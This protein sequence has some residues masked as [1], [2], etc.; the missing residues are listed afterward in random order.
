MA[1]SE[2]HS[3]DLPTAVTLRPATG[4]DMPV[5]LAMMRQ[6]YEREQTPFDVARAERA[7]RGLLAEPVRGGIILAEQNGG[8]IGYMV[9]TF[10]YSLEMAG[11]I[12]LV[13]ELFVTAEQRGRGVGS[14]LLAEAERIA[15]EK[16]VT[17]LILEVNRDNPDATRLY[18]R[19]GYTGRLKY[20]LM[21][22]RL[23]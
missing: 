2:I 13:D 1:T 15:R 18:E 19:A 4:A 6:L 17:T 9:A 10:S 11:L 23:S 8:P 22:R 21:T 5:V 14:A 20:T 7:L 16:G 3:T 12:L